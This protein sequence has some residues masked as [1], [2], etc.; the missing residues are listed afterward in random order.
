MSLSFKRVIDTVTL[1]SDRPIRRLLAY[2]IILGGVFAALLYF[3]P[4]VGQIASGERLEELTAA[5]QILQ[6][7]LTSGAFQSPTERLPSSLQL[8]LTTTLCL[9]STLLLM[10][11]VTWVYMS[12][13]RTK[14]HNQAVVET[15]IMLPLVV[16]S[17]ILIVRNSLALAFSLAGVVAAVRF[18]NTLR[19]TR[20]TVFIFL[21]IGIGFAA[22]VQAITVGAV[23]SVIFNLVL[24]FVWR[25][26]FGRNALVTTASAQ[27]WAEP[28][29]LLA[30]GNG[31]RNGN[32]KGDVA[33]RDHDLVL[34]LSPQKVDALAARFDRVR[35]IAGRKKPRFNALLSFTTEEPALV[36]PALEETLDRFT[37]R[38]MLD[39]VVTGEG[40]GTELSYLVKL[41]KSMPGDTLMTEI[42]SVVGSKLTGCD[43]E[44]SEALEEE[45]EA[46]TAKSPG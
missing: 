19:D 10:L 38:W 33:V 29:K 22:G 14:R 26:D 25:T 30:E 8:A 11:P 43:I 1:G 5:P 13:R 17:V 35:R 40:K 44:L 15:L 27:Q 32:G 4:I 36:Q 37:R 24:L 34:A 7:G 31:H 6:D 18:R 41:R 20:D 21:A 28:L 2:Y 16:A 46:E 12:A 23:V 3:F 9:I 45:T 42:R 39:E